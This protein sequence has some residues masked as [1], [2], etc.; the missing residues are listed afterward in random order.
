MFINHTLK[1]VIAKIVYYGPGLSGKTTN[2]QHIFSV[3]NP[4]N[5]GELV[6]IET[7]IELLPINVGQIKGYDAKFQLY[8]VPGQIFYDS[9]RKMVL[10]G[11][12]G[13]VFVVD[14][15]QLM[16]AANLESYE[17]LKANLLE[18]NLQIKEI[19][20]VF[21]YNKRDLN[22]I[23]AVDKLNRILNKLNKPHF[24]AS[25]IDGSG[26]IG[27]LREISSQTLNRIKSALD[28][29]DPKEI[30]PVVVRFDTDSKYDIMNK[31][32]LPQQIISVKSI[33][34]KNIALEKKKVAEKKVNNLPE[35]KPKEKQILPKDKPKPAA[36]NKQPFDFLDSFKDKSRITILKK[37]N[38]KSPQLLI[39][40][41]EGNAN[42]LDTI[43]IDTTQETKKITLII[44]LT[45][46]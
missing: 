11:A 39:E 15:Q 30:E 36:K 10:K 17:N 20:L 4:R 44:D 26:V 6:S 40:L 13:I 8:T 5:R 23:S 42:F 22:N 43:K 24:E 31:K 46:Q 41:K 29:S 9:T 27:T 38:L 1:Q 25:A 21:Q 7:E 32:D 16:E 33:E 37:L 34:N 35:A 18:Q 12:D 28:H 2:L 3:T 45:K 14:S 19:P